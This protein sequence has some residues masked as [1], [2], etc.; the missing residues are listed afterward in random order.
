MAFKIIIGSSLI[1]IGLLSELMGLLFIIVSSGLPSRLIAAAIFFTSGLPILIIG[2]KFFKDGMVLRPE[3]IKSGI[4]KTAASH[5]GELTKEILTERTGWNNLVTYEIG[6]MIK[7]RIVK[8]E[9]RNGKTFYIF[10]E[11]QTKYIQ[12][13]CPF[14]NNDYPVKNDLQKCPTCGGDLKFLQA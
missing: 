4:L 12:N 2:F 10:P 14:C 13:K 9:E 3:I 8:I 7:R 5:N 1:I 6:D 11:Y